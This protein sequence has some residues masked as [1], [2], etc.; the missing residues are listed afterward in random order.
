MFGRPP[1][2][3]PRR[4]TVP[5]L[6][7]RHYCQGLGDCHL[8]TF[9]KADG[10][11]FHLLI[12]CGIHGSVRGGAALMDAVVADIADVTRH[13]DVLV[14]THEHID[15][16]S[17]FLSAADRFAQLTVGE[18]WM[19]WTENPR[20]EQ[21]RRLDRFR[22]EAGAALAEVGQRLHA[23]TA[24]APHLAGVRAGIDAVLGFQF[25]AAGEKVRAARD[26]AAALATRGVRYLEPSGGTLALDGVADWR[27]YV[28]GPPR[29]EKM[30][31]IT[32][33]TS[34]MYGLAGTNPALATLQGGLG[35][36]LG[37][38]V[39]GGDAGAPFDD[40][41]GLPLDRL[42]PPGPDNSVAAFLAEHY[43]GEDRSW[44][45]IDHDWLA[46][47]GSLAL[48]LDDC[49]NNTSL[50]LA[51]EAVATGRVFLFTG[52]AQIGSWL[53]W[54]DL[55]WTVGSARVTGPDLLARTVF[56]KVGHHG[57]H[58]ATARAKGLALMTSP[59][60]AA[61]VPTS[62]ADAGKVGWKEMPFQP[63]LDELGRRTQGRTVRADDPAAAGSEPLPGARGPTGAIRAARGK[64]GLWVEFDLA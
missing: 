13:I 9:A 59:D 61:F 27:V 45:R 30:L 5:G 17:A 29:D 12:D 2:P 34:E 4:P 56:Y 21:A 58:N 52:D 35:F 33:R 8:L 36:D 40:G 39:P 6:T 20:D 54:Q 31:R 32:Q 3:P 25:G 57:S 42:P 48:Q 23:E 15:H 46:L 63:I 62:Q 43:E 38:G 41:V 53:S 51:F 11:A 28:L 55:A 18:V 16:L 14:V 44:R 22:T 37:D 50:V 60:L 26:A 7:V 24:L 1:P 19:G 47:G 10:G 49:T 64:P